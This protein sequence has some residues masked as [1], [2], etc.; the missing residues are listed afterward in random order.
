MSSKPYWV[1]SHP[2][3]SYCTVLLFSRPIL[4][5]QK[6]PQRVSPNCQTRVLFTGISLDPERFGVA[7]FDE[8]GKVL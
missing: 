7:E 4:E 5:D 1:Y 6:H 8:T 2:D 3:L